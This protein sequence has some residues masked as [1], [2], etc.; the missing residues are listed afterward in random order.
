MKLDIIQ[1]EENDSILIHLNI[2]NMPPVDIDGHVKR[3]FEN[4]EGIFGNCPIAIIPVRESGDCPDITVIR[5]SKNI[6]T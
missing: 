1:L 4:L 3:V 5:Q 6:K 2:G